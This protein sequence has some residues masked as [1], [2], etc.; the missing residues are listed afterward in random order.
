MHVLRAAVTAFANTF[1]TTVDFLNATGH[2]QQKQMANLDRAVHWIGEDAV[3]KEFGPGAAATPNAAFAKA[4]AHYD[5]MARLA[6]QGSRSKAMSVRRTK[7]ACCYRSSF[8][9]V[10]WAHASHARADGA[11]NRS[12]PVWVAERAE[13]PVE[14]EM[15][16]AS[17]PRPGDAAM[18]AT[19]T[20][21][22]EEAMENG[23]GPGSARCWSFASA[24]AGQAAIRPA[25]AIAPK[26]II[27][28]RTSHKIRKPMP[29]SILRPYCNPVAFSGKEAP[30]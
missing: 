10:S 29:R 19:A 7:R 30:S 14:D 20:F 21:A 24:P 27:M 23:R 8:A 18:A 11:A 16:H 3:Q 12:A 17:L 6:G 28:L 2:S 26:P 25:R 15:L 9:S 5:E 1:V 4:A 22:E 13:R